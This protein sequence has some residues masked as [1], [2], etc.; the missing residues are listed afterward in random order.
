MLTDDIINVWQVRDRV[1]IYYDWTSKYVCDAVS[2]TWLNDAKRKIRRVYR[3][4]KW[5]EYTMVAN[6]WE[7]NNK[8]TD[9]TTVKNF[10]YS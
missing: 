6:G 8:A 7:Y 3:M 2:G 9:T 5:W 4:G 10:N 1:K